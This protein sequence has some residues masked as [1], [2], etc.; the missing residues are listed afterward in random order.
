MKDTV[1]DAIE[2][3]S[4]TNV[5]SSMANASVVTLYI[6]INMQVTQMEMSTKRKMTAIP[7]KEFWPKL[8]VDLK[9]VRVR[10]VVLFFKFE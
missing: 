10:P 9:V 7:T 4:D 5:R 6:Y 2:H 3:T 1:I 8:E